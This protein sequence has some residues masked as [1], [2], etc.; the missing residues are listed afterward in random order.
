MATSGIIQTSPVFYGTYFKVVWN[1]TAVSEANNTSTIKWTVSLVTPNA[2]WYNNA[3]EIRSLVINGSEKFAETQQYSNKSH[4]TFELASGTQTIAHNDDGNKTFS[5]SFTGWLIDEG[6]QTASGSFQL[7]Q[8]NRGKPTAALTITLDNSASAA[9]AGWGVAVKGITKV[10]YSIS[11]T[12]Y[13]VQYSI[14]GYQFQGNGQTINAQ[15]GTTSALASSGT[16]TFKGYVKDSRNVWSEAATQ[17]QNVYN[18]NPPKV[19]A[20]SAFRS[21]SSGTE[22]VSGEYITISC[23]GAI[24]T[25]SSVNGN[26]TVA[27]VAYDITDNDTGTSV[28]TGTLTNGTP[29][30]ISVT[31]GFDLNKAYL[32]TFT[33]TDSVGSAVTRTILVPKAIVTFDLQEGGLGAAFGGNSTEERAVDFHE[34]TAIG[35]VFGL[36]FARDFAVYGD[37]FNDFKVPGIYGVISNSDASGC[38]NI[39]SAKAGTLRVWTANGQDREV[40]DTWHYIG[41]L[42]IDITPNVWLRIGHSEGTIGTYT[43]S[44]W[45]QVD[46]TGGGGGGGGGSITVDAALS[47]TS[48]NPVQ[49][50]AIYS[51]LSGKYVKP[52]GGIPASD[53][54]SG[55]IPTVP[56]ADSN[57]PQALGTASAGSSTSWSRGDHV[58]PKP[59]AADIGAIAAP[60]SPATGAFLTFNG[61]AWVAQTLSTWQGG[62]Y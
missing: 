25:D 27:T 18:Y 55:V 1:R 17:T 20:A 28:K 33:V 61:T 24:G 14:T 54:A 7:D 5:I 57:T 51:A 41:Q 50:K 19:T 6:T 45:V 21:N 58:H 38:Y 53:L 23:T 37:D 29:S 44:N 15:T 46:A 42:Y 52:S 13:D 2:S 11:G 59:T 12:P 32:V 22:T 62:N 26:N 43:W 35:R 30:T 16:L 8:I 3:I 36:G 39:P 48:E 40:T 4:G 60:S 10:S 9:V 47:S 34:W 31:G 56:T 49:N